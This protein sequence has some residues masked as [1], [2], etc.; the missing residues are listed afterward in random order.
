M[1]L[2]FIKADRSRRHRK[3]VSAKPRRY[4]ERLSARAGL[5]EVPAVAWSDQ[6][7]DAITRLEQRL[8]QPALEGL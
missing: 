6:A 2:A 4:L 5:D 3:P 8:R 1:S 7:S